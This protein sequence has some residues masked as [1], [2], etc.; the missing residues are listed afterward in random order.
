MESIE[1]MK[2][3]NNALK[4]NKEE[5]QYLDYFHQKIDEDAEGEQEIDALIEKV[6]QMDIKAIS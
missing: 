5:L 1:W 3:Y 2:K 6:E 4:K